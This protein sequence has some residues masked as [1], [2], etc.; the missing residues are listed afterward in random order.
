MIDGPT[1]NDPALR[2]NQIFALSL[3]HPLLSSRYREQVLRAITQQLLTPYGLR[4]LAPGND[5]YHGHCRQETPNALQ[6]ACHQGCAWSWLIGPYMDA[7]ILLRGDRS[8]D[9]NAHHSLEA[10]WYEGAQLL[11]PFSERFQAG[12][13]GMCEA[14]FEGDSPYRPASLTVSAL[15]TAELLR[16]YYLLGQLTTHSHEQVFSY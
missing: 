12:V 13:L 14:F 7:L 5:N 3:R 15:S 9:H 6:L 10:F 16:A 4:T 8:L 2:V 11:S 1:G